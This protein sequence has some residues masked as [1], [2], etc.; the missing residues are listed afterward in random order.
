MSDILRVEPCYS[1][2]EHPV[3]EGHMS[4]GTTG[5]DVAICLLEQEVPEIDLVSLL[6][7]ELRRRS[8]ERVEPFSYEG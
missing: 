8:T 5:A 3:A 1:V 6:L 4:V 2:G 7:V